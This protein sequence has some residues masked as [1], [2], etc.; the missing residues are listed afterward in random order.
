ELYAGNFGFEWNLHSDTQL[1][2]QRSDESEHTFRNKTGFTREQLR[3]KR[4]L[5]VGCGMGRFS[6]VASRWGA[7][8]VGIDL[9]RAVDAAQRNV[10][11]RPN[12]HI[13]QADVF[14]LPFRAETFD[15]IF[16]IGVLHHTPDT[17]K[18]FDNLP[19]LLRRGGTIA[20]WLYA[21]HPVKWW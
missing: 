3:G 14:E 7:T 19:G 13:A 16:S 4:V 2:D 18:A 5:D 20:I 12:V 17:R 21:R 9:S 6:D 15:F 10:G 11:G 1:D 8:V